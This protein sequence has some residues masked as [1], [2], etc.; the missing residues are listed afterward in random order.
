MSPPLQTA[1]QPLLETREMGSMTEAE[2]KDVLMQTIQTEEKAI[3]VALSEPEPA[4]QK[5]LTAAA[6]QTDKRRKLRAGEPSQKFLE[7]KVC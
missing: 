1:L 7:M 2:M 6:T 3:H 5:N 4:R